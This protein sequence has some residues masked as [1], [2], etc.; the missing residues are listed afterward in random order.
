MAHES[1][2]FPVQYVIRPDAEFRGFAGQVAS[3]TM[4]PGDEVL[5]LPSRQK[6]RV[7]SIVTFDGEQPEAFPPMSVTLTLED[8]IDLSRGDMLVSPSEP[9]CVSRHFEA[10]VVWFNAEPLAL[11]RNYLIKHNVRMSR[12]KATKIRFRVNMQTL[13]RDP[14]RE[15]KMNDI[16]AVEFESASPLF[17]DAY[18]RNRTTGSFILIDPISNAT[19][20]A[21]M[22]QR[23][24]SAQFAGAPA[25]SA[26][27]RNSVEDAG[28]GGR[29]LRAPRAP[30]G[31]DSG[32]GPAAAGGVS[33]ERA[34]R[35]RLRGAAG[36]GGRCSRRSSRYAAEAVEA[37]GTGRDFVGGIGGGRRTGC[38]GRR[39]RQIISSISR[40]QGLP[41]DDGQA[42]PAV[43]A[44]VSAL[45]MERERAAQSRN[46]EAR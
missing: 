26:S 20:G 46:C 7:R 13:E 3:G 1:V 18:D 8:E 33:G 34:F 37:G 35:G 41:A 15:L 16:A 6:T 44:L 39:W 28:G 24:L 32:R 19:V 42:V 40:E 38:A 43:L 10:M 11:G 23:D 22:I 29:S 12:A 17:F 25:V 30:A 45:R 27:V 5:A 14:A 4:R 21:A 9:P 2:R 36:V 31:G